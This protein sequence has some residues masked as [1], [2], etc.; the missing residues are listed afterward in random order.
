MNAL[1]ICVLGGTGFVGSRLVTR[2]AAAGHRVKVLTRNRERHR[3]L[4]VLPELDLVNANVHDAGQPIME[5]GMVYT[6]EPGIYIAEGVAGV[7]PAYY[8]IGVRIED[9]I[10][11]TPDGTKN[12][13]KDVPREISEI[14]ALMR[15]KGVGNLA[16]Q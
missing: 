7:D 12:L 13:S 3:H 6:V 10:L 9:V 8:N 14:E 2:L 15:Q 4:L 16:I 5:A 11:V 1:S